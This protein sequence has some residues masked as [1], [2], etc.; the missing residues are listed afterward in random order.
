[1]GNLYVLGSNQYG[2]I[3][4]GK[5]KKWVKPALLPISKK[6]KI[7]KIAAG[8]FHSLIFTNHLNLFSFGK[9]DKGQLGIWDQENRLYPKKIDYNANIIDISGGLNH[10]GLITDEN[11]VYLWGDN[12]YG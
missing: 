11:E 12:E 2:Q 9:N 5:I 1:M 10:S 7:W 8:G 3:G 6:E 4:L